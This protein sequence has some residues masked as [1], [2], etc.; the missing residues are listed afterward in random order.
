MESK[1]TKEHWSRFVV[2]F[3]AAYV[4]SKLIF[5]YVGFEYNIFSDPINLY[6]LFIDFGVFIG[7][8]AVTYWAMNRIFRNNRNG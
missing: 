4:G 2:P 5:N 1:H 8:F 6:K 7:I 3:I